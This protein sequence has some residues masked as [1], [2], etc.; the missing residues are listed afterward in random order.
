MHMVHMQ[1][2][3]DKETLYVKNQ[4][5]ANN[6]FIF[7]F[8][9]LS[10][11]PFIENHVENKRLYD[12]KM[13]DSIETE[14]LESP[15][16]VVDTVNDCWSH[17]IV[18]SIIIWY[19]TY[20]KFMQS[21][22]IVF[23]IRRRLMDYFPGNLTNIDPYDEYKY[24]PIYEQ[25]LSVIPH[26]KILF[27]HKIS[28]NKIF[29]FRHCYHHILDNNH[30]RSI[31]NTNDAFPGRGQT[32]ITY[33]DKEIYDNVK[34]YVNAIRHSL[35]I[36]SCLDSKK[37]V[38]IIERK[39]S[40]FFDDKKLDVLEQAI[41]DNQKACKTPY[42]FDGIIV[43]EDMT[44]K[45][46]LKLFSST[47][48]FFFRH[49]SCLTNLLWAP[50]KSLV[51]DIDDRDDRKNIVQRVCNVSQSTSIYTCYHAFDVSKMIATL[52]AYLE[53]E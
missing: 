48:V 49:G 8:I 39:Y 18:D 20:Q 50:H 45:E 36:Y 21:Q 26:S 1:T 42:E 37:H 25:L 47:H 52:N 41:I 24:K 29:V 38:I 33:S 44:L 23:F 27:E 28:D 14:Y 6:L 32:I 15:V 10:L 19:W 17:G 30:R 4:L 13:C 43:L 51:F 34:S 7:P 11:S 22:E 2:L 40:R 12:E 9:S 46:Q 53:S 16:F 5:Y 3:C 35:H 31:W